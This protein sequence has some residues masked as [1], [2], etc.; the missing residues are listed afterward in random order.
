MT[1]PKANHDQANSRQ[2]K[3]GASTAKSLAQYLLQSGC[4]ENKIVALL[5]QPLSELEAPDMRIPMQAYHR[6]WHMAIELTGKTD[7]G[8]YLGTHP[9]DENMGLLGHIFF[10]NTTLEKALR[11]Y[12]RF[13]KIFNEGMHIELVMDDNLVSIQYICDTPEAYCIP[14]MERT[15]SVSIH[16]AR[17]YISDKLKIEY[18]AFQHEAPEYLDSYHQAFPCPLKFGQAHSAIVF[19]RRFLDYRLPHRSNYLHKLLTRHVESLVKR[20]A[21]KPKFQDRVRRTIAKRMAKDSI[22]AEHIAD[23]LCM[24]RNTLYRRLK[25]EGVSF[26]DLVDEVRQRKAKKYLASKKHSLSD[27]AFLLGFSELS[28]FSRAFKRWTGT[29]PA[30]Y[31][32]NANR[33]ADK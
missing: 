9:N 29:S 15:L 23:A 33:N 3:V 18:V 8:L 30:N 24:S 7:L 27:I 17:E 26:H 22:D 32:K 6:L 4:D 5:D 21:P 13:Y 12:E 14:D 1:R 25:N 19:Q 28:A 2:L 11:Q 16:R 10:N 31:V 20:I